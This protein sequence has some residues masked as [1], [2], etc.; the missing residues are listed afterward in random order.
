VSERIEQPVFL[1]GTTRAGTT[2]LSLM[3][4]HHPRIAFV[5]ELEWVWDFPDRDG[6]PA[7]YRAWLATNRHFLHHRLKADPALPFAGVA[8]SFLEQMRADVDPGGAKPRVGCQV[9]RHYAEAL[10]LWPQ[11]RFIHIVRDGR[12]VCASWIKFGW[13]G[14]GYHAGLQWRRSMEE[15]QALKAVV[16]ASRRIEV[17]FEELIRFPERE[18]RRLCDFLGEPYAPEM[19]R[20]HEDT[21]YEPIDP[22][23]SGK[24][25]KQLSRR[26]LRQF[27]AVAG[28]A[29]AAN[30]YEASGEA[31]YRMQAW[32]DLAFRLEDKVR[33]H[34]AR[35]RLFGARLWLADILTRWIGPRAARDRVRLQLNE[36]E[37]ARLK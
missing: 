10:A 25:R 37:S 31:P 6:D 2:L 21:T 17:R 4:D 18:L 27:E 30:G 33:H 9:H 19:L 29:L 26:D 22:N 23:Q 1:V 34:R 7:A 15:W 14:N 36:V 35:A 3:L 11:A 16:D 24:W 13:L 20:Y 12:D 8:R 5:G 32:S 28:A